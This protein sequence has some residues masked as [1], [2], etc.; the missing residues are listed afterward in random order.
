ML[1]RIRCLRRRGWSFVFRCPSVI[2][3]GPHLL[4]LTWVQW[5]GIVVSLQT[6]L[7]FACKKLLSPPCPNSFQYDFAA[8]YPLYL[9]WLFY[10]FWPV[11]YRSDTALVPILRLGKPG[12]LSG[13]SDATSW[14]SLWWPKE[15]K[16]LIQPAAC[17][18]IAWHVREA[19]SSGSTT[20]TYQWA[21]RRSAELR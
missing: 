12:E 4:P 9:D 11:K 20:K 1:Q 13:N 3:W 14:S 2:C 10:L 17:Q 18:P 5:P 7:I 16:M 19:A 6:L 15:E 8:L 21:Q